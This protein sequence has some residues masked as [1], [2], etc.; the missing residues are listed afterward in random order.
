MAF[1]LPLQNKFGNKKAVNTNLSFGSEEIIPGTP[2][3]RKDL[4]DGIL[5]E[6]NDDGTIFVSNLVEPGSEHE[7]HILMHEVK[8]MTQMKT[9]KLAYTDEAVF[10]IGIKYPRIENG[11]IL[12]E[13]KKYDEGD[14]RLPWESS[15]S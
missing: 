12:F 5:A 7:K 13:G 2:V 1:R 4:E 3:I 15:A 9:G 10:W 14:K 11:Q 6:A 8:H